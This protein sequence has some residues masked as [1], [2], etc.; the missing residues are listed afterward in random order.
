[1]RKT[2]DCPPTLDDKAVLDFCKKG[3][4]CLESVVPEEI[5][6]RTLNY[7]DDL[8]SKQLTRTNEPMEILDQKW[9]MD[10]VIKNPEAAGAIRSLLGKDFGLPILMSSHRTVTPKPAQDWHIDGNSK[11]EPQLNY[12]QVFYLPQNCTREMGPTELIPGSHLMF[13]HRDAIH[14]LGSVRNSHY[15][16]APAGSIIITHYAIWH[17]RSA[18]SV[19]STRENLKYNYWRTTTPTRDW[20][21]DPNFDIATENFTSPAPTYREQFRDTKDVAEMYLWLR[22]DHA[23]YQSVG[24][25]GWP[26]PG[27]R[28]DIPYGVPEGIK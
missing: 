2:Y 10:A 5:N 28:N 23:K 24:G 25:Q 4:L 14:S 26:L 21:I 27:R 19:K 18:S 8:E 15:A 16:S 12:L 3:F 7:L 11:F 20:V 13:T 22:G 17:R 6:Q 9:F 1:M